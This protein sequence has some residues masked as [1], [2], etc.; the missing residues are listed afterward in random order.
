M[1]HPGLE[2]P[3]PAADRPVDIPVDIFVSDIE[4]EI[5]AAAGLADP[6]SVVADCIPAGILK[7]DDGRGP[8]IHLDAGRVANWRTTIQLN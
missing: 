3:R 4:V 5:K 8:Y 7:T 6:V 1:F 2:G